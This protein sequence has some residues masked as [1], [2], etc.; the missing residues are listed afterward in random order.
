MMSLGYS[1]ASYP[2]MP[3][4]ILWMKYYMLE[5][6]K[7]NYER[8]GIWTN[9]LSKNWIFWTN[10]QRIPVTIKRLDWAAP[11]VNKVVWNSGWGKK[12]SK[13]G[14][15]G[16]RDPGS[17]WEK[18]FHGL[19]LLSWPRKKGWGWNALQR[20]RKVGQKYPKIGNFRRVV[21]AVCK[22]SQL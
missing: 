19:A 1:A 15:R 3:S 20:V 5:M 21:I 13:Q 18:L 9:D 7:V 16:C 10:T 4:R 8:D 12:A 6:V 14:W 2:I 17:F 22:V 11:S